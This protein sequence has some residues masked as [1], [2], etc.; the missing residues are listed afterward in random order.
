[1]DQ[2]IATTAFG[3]GFVQ[4]I[5]EVRTVKD[6]N[7]NL[8]NTIILGTITNI[9][10]IVYQYRT[11]GQSLTVLYMLIG[12]VIQLYILRSIILKEKDLILSSNERSH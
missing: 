6:I 4:M 12:L 9:L 1:M 10:W 3:L 7:I 5:E 11:Q 8:K 2:L